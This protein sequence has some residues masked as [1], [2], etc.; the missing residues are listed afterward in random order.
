MV[1]LARDVLA[2]L[3]PASPATCHPLNPLR[4]ALYAVKCLNKLGL[5]NRQRMF[6][7]RELALHANASVHPNVVSMVNIVESASKI[8]VVLKLCP[9]GDLLGMIFDE[10]RFPGNDYLIRRVFLR[11]VDAVAYVHSL[12]IFHRDLKPENILATDPTGSKV[13]HQARTG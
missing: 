11:I 4:Q 6:Q 5:T 12:G 13:G 9:S 7:E 2:A 3:P 1:Y 10:Q 8:Y